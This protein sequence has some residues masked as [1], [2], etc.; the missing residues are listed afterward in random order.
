MAIGPGAHR[1]LI[2]AA[3]VGTARIKVKMAEAVDLAAL[4]GGAPVDRALGT[5]ALV[6]RF[7]ETDLASL[8]ASILGDEQP[9]RNGASEDHSLQPGTSAW[10]ALN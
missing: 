7:A 6:G 1:W 5:A 3:A 10:K 8:L 2:E 9:E 4:H